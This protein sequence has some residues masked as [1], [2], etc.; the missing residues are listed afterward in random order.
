MYTLSA[1]HANCPI[2]GYTHN[3][4]LPED[5]TGELAETLERMAGVGYLK[6]EEVAGIFRLPQSPQAVIYAPLGETPVEPDIVLFRGRPGQLMLIVEAALQAG[7]LSNL[8]LLLRP[9]CMAIPAALAHG[10]VASGGC[11]GNRIYTDVGEDELYVAVPGRSLY[12]LAGALRN[13]AAANSA[14]T[15]YHRARRDALTAD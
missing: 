1:D 12:Q 10:V 5:R 8:P 13:V 7:V 9:T 14:L 11:I 4:P 6:V 15:E 3:L 2:G